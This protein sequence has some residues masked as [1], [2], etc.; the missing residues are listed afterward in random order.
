EDHLAD[1][2]PVGLAVEPH[3]HPVVPAE[4]RDD[5]AVGRGGAAAQIATCG[6]SRRGCSSGS[7]NVTT[8]RRPRTN[9][10]GAPCV[11][12]SITSGSERHGRRTRAGGAAAPVTASAACAAP[13][14]AARR[15][16]P[17]A[18]AWRG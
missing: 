7:T 12:A 9:H 1:L 2:G 6:R 11:G 18:A 17:R 4:A 13:A 10:G 3:P 5:E 15:A 14:A 8:G 16:P